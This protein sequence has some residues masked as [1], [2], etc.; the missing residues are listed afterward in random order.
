MHVDNLIGIIRHPEVIL[1]LITNV[2]TLTG[3]F[4]S[5]VTQ[6]LKRSWVGMY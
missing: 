2:Y 4:R 6:S 3:I 5:S 1:N